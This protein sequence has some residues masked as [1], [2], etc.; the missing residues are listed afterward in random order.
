MEI[1]IL[2]VILVALMA[3]VSTRIKKSAAQ[4]FERESIE[5]EDFRLVKPE[6]FLSVVVDANSEYAFEAYSKDFGAGDAAEY[7]K[8]TVKIYK[9]P[10][11]NK[12]LSGE[13]EKTEKGVTIQTLRKTLKNNKKS[14]ELEIS[15][16]KDYRDEY[17]N[18]I[19]EMLNS[20]SLK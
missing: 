1:L 13:T 5:T 15:V 3:Y 19:N 16:L 12:R 9:N 7:R 18:K 6:G 4:A 17:L 20:F 10:G 14:F 8:A 11:R 2:G